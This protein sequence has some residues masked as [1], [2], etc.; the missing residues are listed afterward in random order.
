[1]IHWQQGHIDQA[2][3]E[4]RLELGRRGD[5]SRLAALEQGLDAGGPTGAMRAMA[6]VLVARASKSY[7]DPFDIA[8]L[9]ARAGIV[10][11]AVH[12]LDKAAGHGSY[13]MTYLAFWPNLDVV[14]DDPRYPDLLRRVY[15]ER[16][17]EISRIANARQQQDQ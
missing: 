5:N 8:E 11:E 10:G 14:R 7:V 17:E 16:A 2:L 3:E 4:D 9:F 6:E 15:G 13:K 12:W 1:M